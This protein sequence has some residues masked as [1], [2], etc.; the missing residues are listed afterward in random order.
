V[1]FFTV[2][3]NDWI[4]GTADLT[5]EET[6]VLWNLCCHYMT[7]D[8]CVPDN[9][10]VLCRVVK[11]GTRAWNRVKRRLIEGAFIEVRDGFI[12]QAKCEERLKLD[13]NFAKTQRE[14]AEKRWGL[15]RA[16]LLE[17]N[18]TADA[19]GSTGADTTADASLS[20]NIERAADAALKVVPGKN[21]PWD[22]GLSIL[23]AAGVSEKQ[24]RSLIGKWR[25]Q[26]N[27]DDPKLL[28]LFLTAQAQSVADPVAYLTK[29][30]G[31]AAGGPATPGELS[32]AEKRAFLE[33]WGLTRAPWAE[34]SAKI[35][36]EGLSN[37]WRRGAA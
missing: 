6:G 17:N 23:A 29:A 19:P 32:A 20:L 36:A 4:S 11:L 37:R 21:S 13:G 14:K 9:A 34:V 1:H 28:S 22:F 10:A 16:K 30:V 24:A 25:K 7:K 15:H 18:E 5:A 2:F 26:L 31:N 3:P 33:K 27:S 12:W 35:D 8:G